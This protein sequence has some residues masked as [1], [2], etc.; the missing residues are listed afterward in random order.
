MKL[1]RTWLMVNW[2]VLLVEGICL[3]CTIVGLPL[4]ILGIIAHKKFKA[5]SNIESDEEL[6]SKIAARE[7]YGWTIFSWF[8]SGAVGVLTFIFVY[9]ITNKK[10]SILNINL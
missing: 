3:C 4:G 1:E 2:I 8:V 9:H 10:Y 5:M 7:N 6:A